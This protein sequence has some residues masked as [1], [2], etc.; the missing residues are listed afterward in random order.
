M[1]LDPLTLARERAALERSWSQKPGL[2]GWLT[3][4]DHKS[5]A[6]RYIVTAFAFFLLGGIEAALIRIQLARPEN[7]LLGPDAYNQI[8]STHGTTMMFLF[9][10]PV[11]TA[12][13][14]Y[15]VPRGI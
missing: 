12:I 15:L 10:V 11:M 5:V 1:T 3:S 9:A 8:F 14:L 6:K 13:G 7:R 4:V 2:W